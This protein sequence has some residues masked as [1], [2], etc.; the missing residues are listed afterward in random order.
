MR[1][2]SLRTR[3]G[4]LLVVG[5]SRAG[6][7][8]LILV[9][10]FRLALDAGRMH[11]SLPPM[12]TVC[13][14]HGHADHIGALC[15]WASQRLLNSLGPGTLYVPQAITDQVS[16]LLETCAG[17]EGGEPYSV[18][19]RPVE[20]GSRCKFK[21]DL[22][23]EF[24]TTDH[25]VPT[26]GSRLVWTRRRLKPALVNEKPEALAQLRAGGTNITDDVPTPLLSYCADTGPGVFS[27]LDRIRAEVML[28]ECSFWRD[29]DIDRARRFGHMHLADLVSVAPKLGCRHLVLLHAS[30][31]NRIS[32]VEK[33]IAAELEP[34]VEAEVHHLIVDWE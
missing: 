19:L 34:L 11:R 9:P 15:Y 29:G 7:G 32:E 31:R 24:F 18:D 17:L 20:N 16:R 10:Q 13:L 2:L 6:E 8:T 30:R 5:G 26:L 12:A 3:W 1:R 21:R 14:S 28:I 4:E 27:A 25:W 23:I 33:L 22:A